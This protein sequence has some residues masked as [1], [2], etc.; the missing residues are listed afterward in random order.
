MSQEEDDPLRAAT[1]G[2]VEEESSG[3]AARKSDNRR[4]L[5]E[6][7]FR[8]L[9]Y[10]ASLYGDSYPFALSRA[11]DRLTL[12]DELTP[13][14]NLY[15]FLLLCSTGRY[16]SK[17]GKLTKDFERLCVPTLNGLLPTASVHVFGTAKSEGSEYVGTFK[18][19]L[20][21][22][23]ANLGEPVGSAV[24]DIGDEETG[25]H[26]LDVAGIVDMGDDLGG[27]LTIFAQAACTDDWQTKQDSPA[28]E[29]WDSLILLTSPA[30]VAC[31]I[32]LCFRN[33][34][35]GWH[36]RSLIHRRLILDRRRILYW[37]E[38]SAA[39]HLKDCVKARDVVGKLVAT[40]YTG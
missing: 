20:A 13:I 16:V 19:K 26:G 27:K 18:K 5:A 1:D 12:T 9:R 24:D 25:D 23:A 7:V 14:N 32:P 2:A 21:R 22:L 15:L 38:P 11:G 40:S 36:N 28:P 33:E 3:A 39:E 37:L 4:R 10:R 8:L 34:Q 31:C 35:G 6:D 17:H 29:A 30:V